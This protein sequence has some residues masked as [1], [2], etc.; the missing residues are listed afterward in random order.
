M[1]AVALPAGI[2]AAQPATPRTAK[3]TVDQA[4]FLRLLTQ[5][6]KNQDP[7]APVDNAQFV[8]QLAQF[9]TVSGIADL[10]TNVKALGLKLDALIAAQPPRQEA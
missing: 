9:S 4:D 7:T 5:Q 6:L 1:S 10:N 3:Q 8:A 2:A